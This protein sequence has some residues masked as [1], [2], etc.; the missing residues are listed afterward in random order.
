MFNGKK[1]MSVRK[2]EMN[3]SR[4]QFCED[5][6]AHENFLMSQPRLTRLELDCRQKK[7]D[8]MTDL[9]SRE[10]AAICRFTNKTPNF[11][12]NVEPMENKKKG[13]NK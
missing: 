6:N 5:L 13:S 10:I 9:S 4:R 2:G 7:N 3:I 12:F 11:Y 8:S 1:L